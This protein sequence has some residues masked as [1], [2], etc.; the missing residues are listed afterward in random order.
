[1]KAIIEGLKEMLKGEKDQTRSTLTTKA[2]ARHRGL[3]SG[4]G[5]RTIKE[6]GMK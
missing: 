4:T 2:F 1:M 3:R 6:G 5:A